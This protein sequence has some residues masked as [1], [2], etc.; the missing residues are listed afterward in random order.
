M[1]ISDLAPNPFVQFEK[2]YC[3]AVRLSTKIPDAFSLL[4]FKNILKLI[5]S[6]ILLELP[7]AV[8][9]ATA[10]KDGKPSVRMVLH[11]GIQNE[12]FIFFTNYNSRKSQELDQNPH[13]ALLFYWKELARQ[14]RVEG[15]VTRSS[16]E[17]SEAYWNTRPR[18]SQLSGYVSPQ[19]KIITDKNELDTKKK[20]ID[21][22]F[23]HKKIPCPDNWGGYELIPTAFEFWVNQEFRFHDRFVYT[24]Q[25]E[26]WALSQLAP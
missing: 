8:A 10:S 5:R 3:E 18:E 12:R 11:K 24:Y 13:A 2:W 19:S 7:E 9:L 15:S 16:R 25:N 14:I 23:I 26:R 21:T 17:V 1:E 4:S 22:L 20:E 6:G